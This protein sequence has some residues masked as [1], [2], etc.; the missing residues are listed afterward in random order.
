MFSCGIKPPS[1]IKI[2]TQYKNQ[3]SYNDHAN[4]YFYQ[5]MYKYECQDLRF[6]FDT[7]HDVNWFYKNDT[8]IIRSNDNEFVFYQNY[9]GTEY[10]V[11]I[12]KVNE[13]TINIK[14]DNLRINGN[15]ICNG[16][17]NDY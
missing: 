6:E 2:E 14:C 10:M 7:V 5:N 8:K 4:W 17:G 11:E 12:T 13:T 9:S 15:F 3:V 1:W 16:W